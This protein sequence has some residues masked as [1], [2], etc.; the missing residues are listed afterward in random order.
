M[1]Q[2]VHVSLGEILNEQLEEGRMAYGLVEFAA[3]CRAALKAD[4]GKDGR[5]KVL[6]L[7]QIALK[8]TAFLAA[9]LP[10]SFLQRS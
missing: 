7:L 2:S 3:D 5:E 9:I 4:L 8:D 6:V 10:E 1:A